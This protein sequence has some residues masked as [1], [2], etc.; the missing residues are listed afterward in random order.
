MPQI[1]KLPCKTYLA[2]YGQA[3]YPYLTGPIIEYFDAIGNL[4]A[5][6]GSA[7]NLPNYVRSECLLHPEFRI[8]EAM[9]ALALSA[10]SKR[11]LPQIPQCAM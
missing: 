11:P 5:A 6:F 2:T 7:C 3:V 10:R 8:G 1:I 4:P 9:Y